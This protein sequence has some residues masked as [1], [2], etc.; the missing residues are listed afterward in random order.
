ME[1]SKSSELKQF[2]YKALA[3]DKKSSYNGTLKIV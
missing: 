3:G 1:W 2:D